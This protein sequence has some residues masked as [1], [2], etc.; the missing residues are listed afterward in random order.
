MCLYTFFIK[1]YKD[2]DKLLNIEISYGLS[3]K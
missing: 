1:F 2:K 3:V